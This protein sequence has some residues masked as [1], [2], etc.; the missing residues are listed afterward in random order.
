M[1]LHNCELIH[2]LSAVVQKCMYSAYLKSFHVHFMGGASAPGGGQLG[3]L[4]LNNPCSMLL[5]LC[6]GNM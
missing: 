6:G 2:R 3:L 4:Q 1:D 5:L